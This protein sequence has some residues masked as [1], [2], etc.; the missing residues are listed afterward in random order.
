MKNRIPLEELASLAKVVAVTPSHSADKIAFYW[1]KTGRFELYVMDLQ[2]RKLEQITNGQA[3]KG[4]RAGFVW[5]R[6]DQSI[7]F[8]KDTDGDELN[9]LY[10][11]HLVSHELSELS[12]DRSQEYPGDVH[13]DNR[14]M[15][16]MSNRNGQ[17]NVFSFDLVT[18]SWQQLTH[19]AA[20]AMAGRWSKDGRWLS[21]VSNE[22]AN[23]NNSDGYLVSSDGSEIRKVFSLGENSHE[24]IADWHPDG[25]RLAVSSDLSGTSQ[26]G[27]LTLESGELEWLGE[28]GVEAYAQTFSE[29]GKWLV[30]LRNQD[31]SV[32][33]LLYELESGK[34]KALKLPAGM[35]FGASFVLNDSKLLVQHSAA[36]R[37]EELLLYDLEHDSFEVLLEADYGSI[38]PD[39]FVTDE[40]LYY[41]SFDGQK[42]PALL[43]RP[44][45]P[46]AKLPALV[47]VHGGPTAQYFRGFDPYAQFLV[48]RG[49]VVLQPNIRGSTGYG[50]KWRDANIKD[51]GGADLEDLAAGVA[52]LKTLSYVDGERI[53]VFGGSFGGF[54][55]FL[56]AVKKPE[57]FKVAVPWVGISDLHKL[58]EEDREHLKYYLRSQM[59]D[60]DKDHALWRDRSA[61]EFAD[62][63]KAKLLIMHGVNDPRC[64]IS[65]A[66]MFREKLLELGRK[67]GKDVS[68]DFEYHE[69]TD[70]GH[71][72]S[73][74][75][76][77]NLRSYKLLADFLERRL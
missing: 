72:S 48:D 45:D 31:A 42:V 56:A 77:G 64:P 68:D 19:F 6:D 73:G 60:P 9:N 13:P 12:H 37:R 66:R 11:I 33:P 71:G 67:E 2:S 26:A 16:V 4:I 17:M 10:Q 5:S 8:A 7:I 38:K 3:P 15:A 44:Q 22:A 24:V 27:I 25:K 35:A 30:Y 21:F 49:Y 63:L 74:D 39:V 69:F 28:T 32:M 52:Y 41:P 54:M 36:N 34:S 20:P 53:G 1:D 65:Q 59:G 18:K 62:R 14:H 75:I 50:V 29:N 70:E 43:Y 40:H 46:V 76:Q 55:S 51:W 47:M 23:L 57:L 61:I 58:Y